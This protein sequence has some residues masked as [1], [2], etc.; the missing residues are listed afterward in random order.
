MSFKR[1]KILIFALICTVLA[2]FFTLGVFADNETPIVPIDPPDVVSITL[3]EM[4]YKTRYIVGDKLD[5]SGAVLELTYDTGEKGTSPVKTDW[6]SGFSST[7]VGEKTVTVKYPDSTAKTTF[8]VEVVTEQSLKINPPNT[9]TYFVGDKEDRSGLT[10]SVVYSNGESA[11]LESG[12]TVSGFSSSSAGEKTVTVKYKDL[13]ATYKVSVFDPALLKITIS[14]KPAKLSYYLG[15]KLDTSGIKVTASY[16]N[17]K[18]AD[19][20]SKITVTGD[21][22]SAGTKKITVTYTERDV[23]KT[24]TYDVTVTDVQIK[25]IVF[26]SYPV[27]TVYAED[28]VFDPTGVSIKVTYNN[29]KVETVSENILY[30][31]FE[32]QTVGEKTITLHYGGY[33]LNFTVT[34]VVSQSHVHKEGDFLQ[35]REPTCTA[36]GEEATTC[37]ICFETV[38]TRP[39]AALGHGAESSPVKTKSQT[40]TEPGEMTTYCLVCSGIVEVSEI[41]PNGHTDGEPQLMPAPTCTESGISKTFC[42]VC[43]AETKHEDLSPLGHSFGEWKVVLEPTGESEGTEERVCSVCTYK[44][45]NALAKLTRT[46]ASEGVSAT[47][48]SSSVFYPYNSSF[49]ADKVTESVTA[50]E[51]AAFIPEGYVIIE[52][53]E[54][55]FTDKNGEVLHPSGDVTYSVEYLLDTA[56]Y[57]SFLICDT[58][59]GMYTP[60]AEGERFSFTVQRSGRFILVGEEIP[61]T[62]APESS[63]TDTETT[64]DV[65]TSVAPV[66]KSPIS[67]VLIIVSLALVAAIAVLVYFYVFKQYY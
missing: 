64:A 62:Q 21:L 37:S 5:M 59:M 33:Q 44:E 43:N 7:K 26:E 14:K 53:F 47:L 28:E 58:E 55:S 18:T 52:V 25:N 57:L 2:A 56:N 54:F 24:A 12:Y 3:K 23:R 66:K 9:L 4:P 1:N 17:G 40:C 36:E 31:G 29:G 32:T 35:T 50:E 60:F 10:V 61:E 65:P 48:N 51:I 16:E 20:T 13:S 63:D 22:D 11:L 46:L 19:V 6:C 42:T 34:V 45:S 38:S 15:E 39:I 27:K 8:K 67:I 49:K 41:A 30:S